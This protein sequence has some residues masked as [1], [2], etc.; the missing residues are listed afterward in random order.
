MV[1]MILNLK[2]MKMRGIVSSGMVMC[3]SNPDTGLVETVTPP[4]GAMPGDRIVCEG[5][6]CGMC[7]CIYVCVCICIYYLC[8]FGGFSKLGFFSK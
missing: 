4:E 6:K 2:P 5:Y 1:M 7:I 8:I 3:A